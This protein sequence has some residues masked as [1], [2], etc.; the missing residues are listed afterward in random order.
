MN[1]LEASWLVGLLLLVVTNGLQALWWFAQEGHKK[2]RPLADSRLASDESQR[3]TDVSKRR[4]LDVEADLGELMLEREKGEVVG[5]ARYEA[6]EMKL[7]NTEESLGDQVTFLAVLL[8]AETAGTASLAWRLEGSGDKEV[9][10]EFVKTTLKVCR[11]NLATAWSM[12]LGQR[13][14]EEHREWF[15]GCGRILGV[16][17]AGVERLAKIVGSMEGDEWDLMGLEW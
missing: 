3:Q 16:D 12:A 10:A 17:Q 2:T 5:K 1:T 6:L 7:E 11:L 9:G 14:W 13:S 15:E 4:K 8:G